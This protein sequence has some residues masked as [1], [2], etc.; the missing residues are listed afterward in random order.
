MKCTDTTKAVT[1][2]RLC[3]KFMA[4]PRVAPVILLLV[5]C[6]YIA[7]ATESGPKTTTISAEQKAATKR[8]L[9]FYTTFTDGLSKAFSETTAQFRSWLPQEATPPSTKINQETAK[10]KLL[11]E[12]E[13]LYEKEPRLQ[14]F[15]LLNPH[16]DQKTNSPVFSHQDAT[17]AVDSNGCSMVK[18]PDG[19]LADSSIGLKGVR[20]SGISAGMCLKF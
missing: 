20:L 6:P 8:P 15:M 18:I 19:S 4:W 9:H 14:G 12:G 7:T 3:H 10:P 13:N 1:A 16:T 17:G 2:T 5:L 11:P